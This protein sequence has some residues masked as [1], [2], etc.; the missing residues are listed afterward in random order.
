MRSFVLQ[1]HYTLSR[2]ECV[3][4]HC[5]VIEQGCKICRQSPCSLPL[6]LIVASKIFGADILF[7]TQKR[8]FP[9][10]H[11]RDKFP[12]NQR[13]CVVQR[14]L[15]SSN[16]ALKYIERAKLGE[17]PNGMRDR[18]PSIR[19]MNHAFWISS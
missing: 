12:P 18:M 1:N 19:M 9:P 7:S 10:P 2:F 17:S 6:T 14:P 5:F 3:F 15:V 13:T 8:D 11:Y 16:T 4:F